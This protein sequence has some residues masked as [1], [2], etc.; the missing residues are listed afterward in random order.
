MHILRGAPALSD[1]RRTKLLAKLQSRLAGV[2]GVY[3]EFMHFAELSSELDEQSAQVLD[4]L[5]RYGPSVP[6]EEP[7]GELVLVVPRF[8]TISPW[9]SKATDIARNCGLSQVLRLERGIAYYVSGELSADERATLKA[10]LHDRMTELALNDLDAAAALFAHTE[11]KPFQ[12]VDILAGGR[13][14]LVEANS[15]L[16]LALAEDEIDYLVESFTGLGRNPSDVELMM[17]A[18]ANSEHC[19]HKIFNASWDIDGQAQDKSLFGMIKNTYQMHS[20]GVLSAYKDNAAVIEGFTAG[21][22]FPVPGSFEYR[23]HE[24]PVHILMKVETHNHPTAIAPFPG[25]STGSGGEIRDEG[26]TGI[27]GKPKAGLTGFTV[28]NLRIPGFVQ[29]WEEDNGKPSRIVTPLQIMIEGPLGG[30][31]FNN[32]FGRPNLNGYFRTFE[33]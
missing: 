22:F 9:S 4:R 16:G 8:G 26:A 30:A 28:S 17:F 12:R 24:E 29:P 6:V 1:F 25:A 23:A 31:A 3:A 2:T 18:Q 5:L 14:A 13:D 15:S 10:E 33:T 21:R 27:G 19:R 7:A 11:P 20:D 32:E